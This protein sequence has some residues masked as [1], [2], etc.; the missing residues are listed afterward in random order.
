[1]KNPVPALWL[2]VASFAAL[3]GHHGADKSKWGLAWGSQWTASPAYAGSASL[4]TIWQRI[5]P[6]RQRFL[7]RSPQ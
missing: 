6:Q 4:M 1:M 3:A 2:A 5:N 7:T